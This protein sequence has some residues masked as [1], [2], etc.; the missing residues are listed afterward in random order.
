M[1]F[2]IG[3]R[4]FPFF[5]V[6][7]FLGLVTVFC[8]IAG[9]GERVAA[10]RECNVVLSIDRSASI[11]SN[12]IAMRTNI[13]NLFERLGTDPKYA[14]MGIKM[15]F[16]TFSHDPDP[17]VNYNKYY[18]DYK[19]VDGTS[20]DKINFEAAVEGIDLDG[21]T[22]YEQALSYS[23]GSPNPNDPT[24][25]ITNL[26]TNAD[27]VAI[28]SDGIPNFPGDEDPN[29]ASNIPVQSEISAHDAVNKFKADSIDP[30][31][32]PIV[33]GFV[34]LGVS[35][36]SMNYT[37]NGDKNNND[38]VGP[39][40]FSNIESSL[41]TKIK[42]AC[43]ARTP[44]NSYSLVPSATVNGSTAVRSGGT[45]TIN[46][47][48]NVESNDDGTDK[49]T[50]WSIMRVIVKPG[51]NENN[52]CSAPSGY[53]D[54]MNCVTI[55]TALAG[56]ML[57][58]D[59]D[60]D[61][62]KDGCKLAPDGT[63]ECVSATPTTC[64][65]YNTG[66]KQ[67]ASR[68]ESIPDGL[69]LGTKVCYMLVL[70]SPAPGRSNR[71]HLPACVMIGKSPTVQVWGGDVRVGRPFI[72][73]NSGD[74]TPANSGV[75]TSIFGMPDSKTYGSWAEYGVFA[76]STIKSMASMSGLAEGYMGAASGTTGDAACD[77]PA[78][79]RLTFANVVLGP[80]D[81]CG[82]YGS[83]GAIPNVVATYT[84]W[85]AVSPSLLNTAPIDANKSTG[86]YEM[87]A[88]S[89]GTVHLSATT[90]DSGKQVVLDFRGRDVVVDGDIKYADQKGPGPSDTYK[91]LSDVPQ[92]IIIANNITISASVKNI[93][94]WLIAN[95][96]ATT[97]DGTVK[98]C[99][100]NATAPFV[101]ASMCNDQLR[102]N[103]PI[104]AR[105]LELWRTYGA[106]DGDSDCD[107][108][109]STPNC[110]DA[111]NSAEVIDLPGTTLMWSALN[112][113][114]KRALTTYSVEL[115]P[116]F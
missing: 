107:K 85:N 39:F 103:G 10:A 1:Q 83:M 82:K 96:H 33:M 35:Q 112:S 16:W 93:D 95:G 43:N 111:K 46:Y 12:L 61:G 65:Q 7:A 79:N 2:S 9:S 24:G 3:W 11:G 84:A 5:V 56:Y 87:N 64:A 20:T 58:A 52:I 29:D 74:I 4:R 27:V 106:E 67:V 62:N 42:D 34:L 51:G 48:V 17:N 71:Y 21:Q 91:D 77:T 114:K 40:G 15:G 13:K 41:V 97:T 69:A 22:N 32:P 115:P 18:I 81:T 104:M 72:D 102:V 37:I 50:G 105:Y 49:T 75:Y 108:D 26:R 60:G 45:A 23:N 99:V 68:S 25:T 88:A 90:I 63:N 19:P 109:A 59:I 78:L 31:N 76:P 116:Y 86:R 44:A 92:L 94:A 38:N 53:C 73:D 110:S 113:G 30:S 28:I 98:T 55:G 8:I 70:N 14:G 36:T 101:T 80:S 89:T 100:P 66:I 57:D 6:F 54:N 47:N